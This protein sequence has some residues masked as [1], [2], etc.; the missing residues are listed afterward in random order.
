[1]QVVVKAQIGVLKRATRWVT[2]NYRYSSQLTTPVENCTLAFPKIDNTQLFRIPTVQ[3]LIHSFSE[4]EP[5]LAGR[6]LGL[7]ELDR[8]VYGTAPRL[9]ILHRAMI[10]EMNRR[11]R[12][13]ESSKNIFQVRGGGR[14]P[15]PQKGRGKARVRSLRAG[16]R[17]GGYAIHGPQPHNRET[18]LQKRVYDSA[19]RSALSAKFAQNQIV[20]VDSLSLTSSSAFELLD[21]LK[22]LNSEG[23]TVLQ[24]NLRPPPELPEWED[25]AKDVDPVLREPQIPRSMYLVYGNEEPEVELIKSSSVFKDVLAVSADMLEIMEILSHEWLILDKR[26]VEYL[27]RRYKC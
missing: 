15:F 1:M 4:C 20:V 26:A 3:T 5:Q 6:A 16:H 27:E 25:P 22:L 9:D 13:T 19:F 11:R 7:I 24:P 12:G 21:K 14:K 18:K 10:F 23:F 2:P 8:R 17:V